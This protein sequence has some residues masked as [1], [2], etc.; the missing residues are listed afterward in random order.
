MILCIFVVSVV[1][2]P[3]AFLILL[4]WALSLFFLM[5]LAKSLSILFIFS[6]NQLSVLLTFS[7]VFFV[8]ISFISALIFMISFLLLTLGFVC[9][10]S[11]CF[12][13]KVRCLFLRLGCLFQIFLVSLGKLVLLKTSLSELLFLISVLLR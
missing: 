9:S 11:S 3:F 8:S 13:Y 5:S 1:T 6:K 10:F 4:V 12:R 2:S 7:I